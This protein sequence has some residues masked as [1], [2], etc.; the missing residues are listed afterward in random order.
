MKALRDPPCFDLNF[1]RALTGLYIT[2]SS[3]MGSANRV[4][5]AFSPDSSELDV[6]SGSQSMSSSALDLAAAMRSPLE[7]SAILG[8]HVF[9]LFPVAT[10][11]GLFALFP[12]VPPPA[13]SSTHLAHRPSAAEGMARF[14]LLPDKRGQGRIH[15][16]PKPSQQAIREGRAWLHSVRRQL[17]AVAP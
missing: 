15:H 14:A 11:L 6:D 9:P 17:R 4:I 7:P 12:P 8:W 5:P 3:M 16:R 10:T 13:R 2:L 1:G